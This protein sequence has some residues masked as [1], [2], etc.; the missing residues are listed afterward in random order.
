MVK[1]AQEVARK[2][3]QFI[4]CLHEG[5]SLTTSSHV[6]TGMVEHVC[7]ATSGEAEARGALGHSGQ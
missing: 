7:D 5:L 4:M 6:K 1:M 2:I 3:V